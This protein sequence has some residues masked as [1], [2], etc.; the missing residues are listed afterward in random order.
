MR[1]ALVALVAVAAVVLAVAQR[2]RLA[3][4]IGSVKARLVGRATIEERLRS[5]ESGAR[6]RLEP[7]LQAKGFS[8]PLKKFT[9]LEIKDA[10]VLQLFAH[11]SDGRAVQIKDYAVLA[12]SGA[13]GPKL[14]EGD[15]QIP[16]GVYKV[17]FLNPNSL[18]H[19]SL[20]LDYP[21]AFDRQMASR[22]GRTELGGDIMIHGKS[23]SI[24]C[25]AVGDPAIE[26]IFCLAARA[27]IENVKVV[28]V[29]TD[30]RTKAFDITSVKEPTWLPELYTMLKA[31]IERLR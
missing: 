25:V 20:R 29:P 23:V 19:L 21:N 2:D 30:W 26:E 15:R 1:R 31:E 10:S 12:K 24:G 28:I 7:A 16:E 9:L 3:I 27:G 22:D 17:N 13:L 8:Y 4:S 14:R 5:Y 11:D 18:Y 6:Q